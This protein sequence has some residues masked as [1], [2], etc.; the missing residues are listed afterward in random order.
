LKKISV[1]IS[2]FFLCNL[3]VTAQKPEVLKVKKEQKD[4]IFYQAGAP[5]DSV[6]PDKNNTFVLAL[7]DSIV[8]STEIKISNGRL[9]YSRKSN[10]FNLQFLPT[11][12]YRHFLTD[13]IQ[14]KSNSLE[15]IA[16]FKKSP[17]VFGNKLY[18]TQINGS[19]NNTTRQIVVEFYNTKTNKLILKNTFLY[20]SK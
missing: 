18:V 14:M 3:F 19:N 1:I 6:Y 17:R 13:S 4:F 8:F 12:N 7:P 11:M 15:E 2:L 16:E 5:S 9:M 20:F 10:S